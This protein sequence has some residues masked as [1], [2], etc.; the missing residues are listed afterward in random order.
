MRLH[1]PYQQTYSKIR[2][3]YKETGFFIYLMRLLGNQM[4]LRFMKYSPLLQ[5]YK[6]LDY[7]LTY[8]IHPHIQ[9]V[10]KK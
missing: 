10:W 4:R 7:S 9:K 5:F 8:D 3:A 6:Q 2:Y 1:D